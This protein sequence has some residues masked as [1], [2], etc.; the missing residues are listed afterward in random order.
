[1]ELQIHAYMYN[2]SFALIFYN[3]V[4]M[5]SAEA[6]ENTGT[7]REDCLRQARSAAGKSEE[8]PDLMKWPNPQ[9][10]E[11]NSIPLS[12]RVQVFCF[13]VHVNLKRNHQT[14]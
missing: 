11:Q 5:R 1:M 7:V 14:N 12:N 10:L 8:L 13:P 2:C 4:S 6:G 3:L 9:K